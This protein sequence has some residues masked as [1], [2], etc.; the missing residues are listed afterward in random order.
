MCN[1][2]PTPKPAKGLET[3]GELPVRVLYIGGVT[4][5]YLAL[6]PKPMLHALLVIERGS[7]LNVSL[8]HAFV[9]N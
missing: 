8:A 5:L 3:E 2:T 1:S 6:I 9:V 4:T 7:R